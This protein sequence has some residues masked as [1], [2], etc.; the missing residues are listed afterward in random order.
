MALLNDWIT[1][2]LIIYDMNNNGAMFA[3]A[4]EEIRH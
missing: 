2:K 1:E 3:L 4:N